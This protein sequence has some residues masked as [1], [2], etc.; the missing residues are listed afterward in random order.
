MAQSLPRT[1][2]EVADVIGEDNAL[3]LIE[4][5]PPTTIS[6]TGRRRPVVYVPAVLPEDHRL[7]DILGFDV[8]LKLTKRFG[9]ELLFMPICA[10][11]RRERT[12]QEILKAVE[13]GF[14]V[15]SVARLFDIT[16]RHV[17]RIVAADM[18]AMKKCG[19]AADDAAVIATSL[20]A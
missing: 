6:T 14:P 17:R 2:Q 8:A 15:A 18:P 19:R 20:N 1:M 4:Q 3:R 16:E 7:A 11:R 10:A 13:D 12:R 9:G 5:W